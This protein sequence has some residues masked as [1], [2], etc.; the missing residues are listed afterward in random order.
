MTYTKNND[1]VHHVNIVIS[2]IFM[3]F[4]YIF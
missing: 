1:F 2:E 3:S 4:Q